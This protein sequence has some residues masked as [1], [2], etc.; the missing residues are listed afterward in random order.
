MALHDDAIFQKYPVAL[1]SIGDIDLLEFALNQ[2]DARRGYAEMPGRIARV[3]DECVGGTQ[4]FREALII[5]AY[6]SF[7]KEST[8][9][10][11]AY[12]DREYGPLTERIA[13]DMIRSKEMG[14]DMSPFLAII[15]ASVAVSMMEMQDDA[16][17]D[18]PS[19]MTRQQFEDSKARMDKA[20]HRLLPHVD[21]R[22]LVA[23]YD[24]A[25]KAHYETL[26]GKV[27]PEVPRL[28]PLSPRPGA[29]G[30]PGLLPCKK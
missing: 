25:L 28:K 1:R 13:Y 22:A 17:R 15:M 11:I 5:C 14:K 20:S 16:L 10:N 7:D 4:E 26:A 23:R 27:K 30:R 3:I 9:G 6:Y 24:K 8:E 29:G 21:E 2:L 12:F 19:F 18:S